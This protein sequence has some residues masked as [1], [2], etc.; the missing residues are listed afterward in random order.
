MRNKCNK[1]FTWH[2]L[3]PLTWHLVNVI[4]GSRVWASGFFRKQSLQKMPPFRNTRTIWEG[5]R[6]TK[7]KH[8]FIGPL[9][10]Q[11]WSKK[12][13]TFLY[14]TWIPDSNWMA[15]SPP[16]KITFQQRWREWASQ[17]APLFSCW[18][19]TWSTI[20][21]WVNHYHQQR[22]SEETMGRTINHYL[23]RTLKF[24]R[25]L[26]NIT[27][28]HVS[29]SWRFFMLR[30]VGSIFCCKFLYKMVLL[31][32]DWQTDDLW[33]LKEECNEIVWFEVLSLIL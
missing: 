32:T 17:Q 21:Y 4:D 11:A 8:T 20:T 9:C 5:V 30:S 29:F 33:Q 24:A 6:E 23:G 16:S 27:H 10:R 14:Q 25:S 15:K 13:R 1:H 28:T 12:N 7:K 31:P 22:E 18:P 2:A 19:P 3:C 26:I